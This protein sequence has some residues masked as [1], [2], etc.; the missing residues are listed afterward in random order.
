MENFPHSFTLQHRRDIMLSALHTYRSAALSQPL[1]F[2]HF[3]S[4]IR[5]TYTTYHTPTPPLYRTRYSPLSPTTSKS[6]VERGAKYFHNFSYDEVFC[7]FF[8]GFFFRRSSSFGLLECVDSSFFLFWK[9]NYSRKIKSTNPCDNE[10]FPSPSHTFRKCD[11]SPIS[12]RENRTSAAL[13][14]SETFEALNLFIFLHTQTTARRV[15]TPCR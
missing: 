10:P 15:T 7:L 9:K 2:S 14:M 11:F 4:D 12:A 5:S 6:C 1:E 13:G 3:P 8:A